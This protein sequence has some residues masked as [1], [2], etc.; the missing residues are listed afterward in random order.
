[1]YCKIL[2]LLCNFITVP[3]VGGGGERVT[4]QSRKRLVTKVVMEM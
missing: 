2:Y 4:E 1:M 3:G